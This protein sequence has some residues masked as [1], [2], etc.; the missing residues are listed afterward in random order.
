MTVRKCIYLLKSA[1]DHVTAVSSGLVLEAFFGGAV[2]NQPAAATV[3]ESG[4]GG[5]VIHSGRAARL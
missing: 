5:L 1:G 2:G 4:G 3:E